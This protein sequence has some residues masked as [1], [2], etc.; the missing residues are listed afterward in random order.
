MVRRRRFG[1]IPFVYVATLVAALTVAVLVLGLLVL[2]WGWYAYGLVLLPI[3]VAA[4]YLVSYSRVA[5]PAPSPPPAPMA[6]AVAEEE[7]VDPVEE[8]DRIARGE[9][10]PPPPSDE[11]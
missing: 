1:E 4:A 7:F 9:T 8:A 2:H 3:L 10:V 6:P 5:P 11:P